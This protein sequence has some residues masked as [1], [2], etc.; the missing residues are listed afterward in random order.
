MECI[1]V[2]GR[3]ADYLSA[4]LELLCVRAE[5]REQQTRYKNEPQS[6]GNGGRRH[7]V[8]CHDVCGEQGT[9]GRKAKDG[10]IDTVCIQSDDGRKF[11]K[12]PTHAT[13]ANSC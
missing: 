6:R 11:F 1:S 5:V 4:Y 2:C 10:S 13:T 3:R 8:P 9:A 7:A 12:A